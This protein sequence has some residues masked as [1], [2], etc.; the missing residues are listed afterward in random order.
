MKN[1]L[2][3]LED[4]LAGKI[5]AE[6][7]KTEVQS[8]AENQPEDFIKQA[9]QLSEKYQKIVPTLQSFFFGLS[10]QNLHDK[11]KTETWLKNWKK[12]NP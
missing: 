4:L 12:N 5:E 7:F 6:K 8:L 10:G 9:G 1:L 2:E 11:E 3:L